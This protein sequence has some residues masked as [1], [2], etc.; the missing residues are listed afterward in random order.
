MIY[1][2]G[3]P[4]NLAALMD[5]TANGW[6]TAEYTARVDNQDIDLRLIRTRHAGIWRFYLKRGGFTA[7]SWTVNR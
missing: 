1:R 7:A 2:N 4:V 5:D 6:S 3:Q